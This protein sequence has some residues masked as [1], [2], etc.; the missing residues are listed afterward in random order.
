VNSGV[1]AEAAAPARPC[2]C[3]EALHRSKREAPVPRIA[4]R[5]P[6]ECA[7]SLGISPDTLQRHGAIAG[8]RVYRLGSIRLVSIEELRRF[9]EDNAEP[10]PGGEK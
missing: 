3:F 6:E 4:L 2:P 7:E 5:W 9:V 10:V 1:R 8:V